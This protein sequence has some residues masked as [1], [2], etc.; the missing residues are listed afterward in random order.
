MSAISTVTHCPNTVHSLCRNL[1]QRTSIYHHL[2]TLDYASKLAS[3][4]LS[5]IT[6]KMIVLI[7]ICILKAGVGKRVGVQGV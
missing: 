7:V 4:S 6:L 3:F 5:L 1:Q 2:R